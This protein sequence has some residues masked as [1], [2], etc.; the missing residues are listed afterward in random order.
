MRREKR[1]A[2]SLLVAAVTAL[3]M[4]IPFNFAF[5]DTKDV[6]NRVD[7]SWT[8]VDVAVYDAEGAVIPSE[9]DGSYKN[10]PVDAEIELHGK[11]YF[12]NED[13]NEYP[14][15]YYEGDF[16]TLNFPPPIDFGIP[17]EGLELKN[18]NGDI[19][20]ILTLEGS[21]AKITFTDYVE[22][23]NG[24][25]SIEAEFTIRGTFK[26]DMINGED[27]V[28]IDVGY[29]GDIIEIGV[30]P[31]EPEPVDLDLS[32]KAEPDLENGEIEWT[33]NVTPKDGKTASGVRLEDTFS[34]NQTYVEGSFVV[35]GSAVTGS[36][37][38]GSGLTVDGHGFTYV[39][40]GPIEGTQVITYRT[41]ITD[42]TFSSENGTELNAKFDNEVKAFIGETLK[43]TAS[44]DVTLD[45]INKTAETAD[46]GKKIKWTVTINNT[47]GFLSGK[48]ASIIDT[49]GEH[50][51]FV[52]DNEFPVKIRL[53]KQDE[54]TVENGSDYGQYVIS[55][56]TLVYKFAGT[57]FEKAVLTYY[58]EINNP[59][60]TDN[61]TNYYTNDAKLIWGG[62]LSG[63]SHHGSIGIGM[64]II[65]KSATGPS[66]YGKNTEINWTVSI[67]KNRVQITDAV[68]VDTI[69][70][71]LDYKP[72]SFKLN[73]NPVTPSAIQGNKL[74]YTIAGTITTPQTITYT[75][76]VNEEF[77]GLFSNGDSDGNISFTNSATLTGTGIT[78]TPGD[79]FEK[80]LGSQVIDKSVAERYDYT[81][82]IVKWKIV[83]NKNEIP[84]TGL[85]VTDTIP[86]GMEFLP[87]SFEIDGNKPADGAL[88][89]DIKGEDNITDKDSFTY[90]IGG[91]SGQHEIIYETMVKEKYLSES[92]NLNEVLHFNNIATA[93]AYERSAVTD[94][95][96]ETVNNFIVTKTG[97][98]TG[99]EFVKWS[100][101]VNANKIALSDIVLTDELQEGLALDTAS[102]ELYELNVA[103]DGTQ[104]KG[105]KIDLKSN[106]D[107]YS[108]GY[109]ETT[110]VFTFEFKGE[111]RDAY[112]LEFTTDVTV[113]YIEIENTIELNG[114]GKSAASTDDSLTINVNDWS[115]SG[116]ASNGSLT[117]E[118]T[119]ENGGELLPGAEFKLYDKTGRTYSGT[120]SG[121]KT[122]YEDLPFRWYYI[123][124]EKAPEGYLLNEDVR[125]IKL[126]STEGITL[127]FEDKKALADIE[128]IKKDIEGTSLPG[129]GFTLYDE[130]H[131]L[132]EKVLSNSEGKVIF[133][134][135]T[136]G[137][138]TIEE[139]GV[140]T[141]YKPLDRDIEV[142]VKI[143][144]DGTGIEV[145]FTYNGIEYGN[146]EPLIVS[147]ELVDVYG[148][149]SLH[150]IDADDMSLAGAEFTLYD[151]NGENAVGTSTSDADGNVEFNHIP[152][153]TYV[154]KETKAPDG[155]LKLTDE[156][157]VKVERSP[158]LTEAVVTYSS[159]G[160]VFSDDEPTVKNKSVDIALSKVDKNSNPLAGA[161]FTLY[162]QDGDTV[163]TA[164]SNDLGEVV[165]TAVPEGT[166]T[167]KETR[168]P[169]RYKDYGKVIT[170]V[171]TVEDSEAH[172]TFTV[173][174]ADF[175]GTVV[176]EKKPG[177]GD[178][179]PV[180][181]KIAVK[182]VDEDK[183]VLSGAEFTL[184]GEDGKVVDKGVTGSDGIVSFTALE[185]GT[186]VLKETDA[187][188]GYVLSSEETEVTVK[189]DDVKTFTFTNKKEEPL[190][191]G[192]IEIFKTDE[193]GNPLSGAWFS[194]IDENG[195]TL[196]NVQT[197][198]GRGV[199]E[200]VAP[201]KYTVKEVQA[202][203][204]YELSSSQVVSVT[205][206]SGETVTAGFVNRK[207]GGAATV[208]PASGNILINKVD[209]NSMPLPGA[210]FILYNENNQIIGTAVSDESGSVMFK[211]L[212]EG[213]YFVKETKAP[214]GY[215]PVSDI[216]TV[217]ISESKTYTYRF[218]NVP[219]SVL[220]EDPDIPT[221]WEIIDDPDVPKDTVDTLPNT[222]SLLNTW[223][224]AAMGFVLMLAG[225]ALYRRK[226]ARN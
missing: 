203:A 138:Y 78:G 108:I 169:S 34:D 104:T 220:I 184:Y 98:R 112:L 167:I 198:D 17:D 49:V 191:P 223:L 50:H 111:I 27:P 214:E 215:E 186:Y 155:Y 175:D 139:T 117:I 212:K 65:D 166:Y 149:I 54:I 82:R 207:Q 21:Q 64:G 205:A 58:T 13:E 171:V 142:E 213:K 132:V 188:E 129:V 92:D 9:P 125:E 131:N 8:E 187:P 80:K 6:G 53:D 5:G 10:V 137:T 75:T 103:S 200:D 208:V 181:G 3:Q 209:E 153:G 51:E 96:E 163:Q 197:V 152:L 177:G 66:D 105:A 90:T 202:P 133:S 226:E 84:L 145:T 182:K 119:D 57:I 196:Q 36:A 23:G 193:N 89:Y 95:A 180:L 18:S 146:G 101:P 192:G 38:T 150:K 16:F 110:R 115:G 161:E 15:D 136:P 61:T 79:S 183:K 55:D 4:L 165:F 199:F 97:E 71:G 164:V 37:V 19:V 46:G 102:V 201:G 69:P 26:E 93:V 63:P 204:G 217:D 39:F 86:L 70:D 2:I 42:M 127:Q 123:E 222:G 113:D 225:I 29:G 24:R 160:T 67:N 221:G 224:L 74:T 128:F 130:E 62:N 159:D 35:T 31:P 45:W 106:A 83:V 206:E 154:I 118:K 179:T 176:N 172:V 210:E 85:T 170:A 20:G 151:G 126:N 100:V 216:L 148:D 30:I 218:R 114:L 144:E 178:T 194:L 25:S 174:G 173:D 99:Y 143:N 40:P 59:G 135:I 158:S 56:K 120:E 7:T 195:S 44:D 211:N 41:K 94:T 189:S 116:S 124:E 33:I 52:A 77:T 68:F 72:G 43:K 87:G 22:G 47:D 73:G 121:G 107:K 162:G 12:L 185:P 109:D 1:K 122:I 28:T 32:K 60:A 81:T 157:T 88:V 134:D 147:N 141:G 168:V 11:F 156:I 219:S 190:K 76:V 14:Y 48:N 140:P 91:T